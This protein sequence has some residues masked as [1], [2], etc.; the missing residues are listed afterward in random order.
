[1]AEFLRL[2]SLRTLIL[3]QLPRPPRSVSEKLSGRTSS[4]HGIELGGWKPGFDDGLQLLPQS[5]DALEKIS[6]RLENQCSPSWVVQALAAARHSESPCF[7]RVQYVQMEGGM[8]RVM[9]RFARFR[10]VGKSTCCA[11]PFLGVEYADWWRR[12]LYQLLPN[13]LLELQVI[14]FR[15]AHI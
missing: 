12:G 14:P 15:V 8:P 4:L 2:S 11:A 13:S 9:S 1:L 7:G 5:V 10:E 6:V 3:A